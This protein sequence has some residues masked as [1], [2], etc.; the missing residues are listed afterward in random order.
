MERN[1]KGQFIKGHKGYKG[2]FG[3]KHS[4]ETIE[5]YKQ[6]RQGRKNPHTKEWNE[7]IRQS[8]LERGLSW[9]KKCENCGKEFKVYNYRPNAKFC[10]IKCRAQKIMPMNPFEKGDIPWNKGLTKED[11]SRVKKMSDDRKGK[12]NWRWKG[13]IAKRDKFNREEN[14]WRKKVFKRD[15]YICQKCDVKGGYLISHHIKSWAICLK[16]RFVVSNGITF[17]KECHK[18]FHKKYGYKNNSKQLKEFLKKI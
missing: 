5:K 10:S 3:R 17:C 2:M 4:E 16:L 12:K 13:G 18:M 14:K 6:D 7:K 8:H 1:K 9:Y 15:G 11:D